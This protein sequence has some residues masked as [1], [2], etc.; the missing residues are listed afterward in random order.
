MI[1]EFF[2]ILFSLDA[3]KIFK[4]PT[5][6]TLLQFFRYIFVG[7]IAAIADFSVLF[8]FERAGLHYL[9]AAVLGFFAGLL[10]N[11]LLSKLFVFA[12]EKAAAKAAA[13]FIAYAVIGAI[14]LGMTEA[15]MYV[16]AE[17]L[18]VY[19]MIGKIAATAIVFLWNFA[20][21]KFILYR[22]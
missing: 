10:V 4:A 9:A 3:E 8:V 7:G 13:E 11:Y 17:L 12:A 14:G 21:R 22:K 1:K 16:F 20:A 19:Y 18:K 6:N 5:K 15:I 2:E